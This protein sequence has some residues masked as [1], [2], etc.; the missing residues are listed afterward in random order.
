MI[1]LVFYVDVI[2][3]EVSLRIGKLT[4]MRVFVDIKK[5]FQCTCL[6]RGRC[7]R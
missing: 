1:K 4:S 2:S 6:L 5:N 7:I 3:F